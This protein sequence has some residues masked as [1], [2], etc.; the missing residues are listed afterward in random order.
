MNSC[1]SQVKSQRR[2]V[3]R[4]MAAQ[5]LAGLPLKR[6]IAQNPWAEPILF[7]SARQE[8]TGLSARDVQESEQGQAG[9]GHTRFVSGPGSDRERQGFGHERPA[10]FAIHLASDF[11]QA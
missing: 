11:A 3:R 1:A 10:M 2:V 7:A 6:R 5:I 4:V 8:P 9:D